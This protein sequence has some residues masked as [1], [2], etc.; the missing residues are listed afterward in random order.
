MSKQEHRWHWKCTDCGKE[1]PSNVK[2]CPRCNALL[3]IHGQ[4]IPDDPEPDIPKKP[5]VKDEP[6]DHQK[7]PDKPPKQKEHKQREPKERKR[8][9]V[10]LVILIVLLILVILILGALVLILLG[11]ESAGDPTPTQPPVVQTTPV[12]MLP[13]PTATSETQPAMTAPLATDPPATNPPTTAPPQTAPPATEPSL[14]PNTLKATIFGREE[15]FYLSRAYVNDYEVDATYYAYNPRGEQLYYLS[16]SFDKNLFEGTYTTNSSIL[17]S[18]VKVSFSKAGSYSFYTSYP[19]LD[20]KDY[21]AGTFIIEK[22]SED[23]MTY[24][25]S[26]NMELYL[27]KTDSMVIDDAVFNFTLE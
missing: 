24:E 9:H 10:G 6:V 19:G 3:A 11:R 25:G 23:W 2:Y 7:K 13:D 17:Y 16:L 8:H 18:D 21:N 14:A 20:M 5:F 27:N 22:I 26:F 12:D 4:A 1:S 15:I